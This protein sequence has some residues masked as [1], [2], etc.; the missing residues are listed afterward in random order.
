MR[1]RTTPPWM[2]CPRIEAKM[3]FPRLVT[4]R[5]TSSISTILLPTRNMMPKGIYLREGRGHRV[6]MCQ[7]FSAVRA[8]FPPVFSRNTIRN[9]P[10]ISLL[11]PQNY[12]DS[13]DH[14]IQDTST[15]VASLKALKNRISSSPSSPSFLSAT[16]NTMANNTRP[17]MFMPSVSVPTGT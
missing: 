2:T 8:C 1:G 3:Y 17:R 4:R 14:M 5:T 7:R 9:S 16:P 12:P 13:T 11:I 15:I 10:N 6:N